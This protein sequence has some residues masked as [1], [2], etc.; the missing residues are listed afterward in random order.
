MLAA[1]VVG[2]EIS[3]RFGRCWHHLLRP[4]Y[5][6]EGP[7]GAVACAARRL[8]DVSC[9]FVHIYKLGAEVFNHFG[10]DPDDAPLGF[11]SRIPKYA[12]S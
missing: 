8:L 5:Q 10:G 11:I 2:Y 7:W 3:H 6:A 1:V 12:Q 4:V 9:E